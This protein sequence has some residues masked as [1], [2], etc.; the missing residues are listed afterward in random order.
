[1]TDNTMTKRK[2]TKGQTIIPKALRGNLK[3][4]QHHPHTHPGVNSGDP[5]G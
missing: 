5:E 3:I 2:G 4:E 1:M